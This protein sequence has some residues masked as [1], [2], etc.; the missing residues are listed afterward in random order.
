MRMYNSPLR[1]ID[2]EPS[3]VDGTSKIDVLRVHEIPLVEQSGFQHCLGAQEHKT[4]AQVRCIDRVCEI[5]V[6]QFVP[7]V[8]SCV[9]PSGDKSSGSHI[10]W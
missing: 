2:R 3:A 1:L 6:T 5:F 9:L 8:S 4:T 7:L 10:P